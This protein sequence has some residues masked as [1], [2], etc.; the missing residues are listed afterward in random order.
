MP[1]RRVLH[2][3]YF[4]QAKAEGYLARSAYK[5]IE[6]QEKKSLMRPGQRVLDLGCAPGAWLQAAHEIV[7]ER[8][9]VVGVDF[10]PVT[11]PF[12]PNVRTIVG[13]VFETEPETLLAHTSGA[14]F[15]VVLSDMAPNT[16]G[17]DDHFPSVRLCERVLDLAPRVLAP[18]GNLAMKV[19]EGETYPDLLRRCQR[20]FAK[21][22]G[23]KPKASRDVSREMYVVC[24]GFTGT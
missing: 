4:K 7:G 2:D 1:P 6:L 11:H 15:D 23:F 20:S 9:V 18:T 17:H 16:T 12:P 10:K 8:G 19:F 5:L 24:H 21:V 13:D 14:L 3:R 22:K